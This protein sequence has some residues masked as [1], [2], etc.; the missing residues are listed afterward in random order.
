[1]SFDARVRLAQEA[2]TDE[3]FKTYRPAMLRRAG[4]QL[5]RTMRHCIAAS[6]Q[7]AQKSVVLVADIS[8]EGRATAVEVKPDNAVAGCVARGFAAASYPRPPAYPG[9]SGF[10]VTMKMRVV[11]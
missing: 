1:M 7:P 4:R 8:A 6:P 9:R 10:P 2:E 11:R 5:A 3:R